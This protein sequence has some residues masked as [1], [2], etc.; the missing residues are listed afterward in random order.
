MGKAQSNSSSN[1][2]RRTRAA[3][4]PES[5]ENQLISLAFDEAE[6]QL[7]D[8][9]ASS[10]IITHFLKLATEEKK[11]EREKL[12]GENL[13]VQAKTEAIKS[14]QRMDELYADAIAA[15]RRYGGHGDEE[16]DY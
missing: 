13:L 8:G 2:P 6:K 3:L 1:Q 9:T 16:D 4:T 15:M 10:Q 7:R 14:Q 11:L 12:R 5:R